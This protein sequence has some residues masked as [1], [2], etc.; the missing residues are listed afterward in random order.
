V[1]VDDVLHRLGEAVGGGPGR[2]LPGQRDGRREHLGLERLG[3]PDRLG[4][5]GAVGR[6]ASSLE[7]QVDVPPQA[8]LEHG[9]L[10]R[11]Q[12]PRAQVCGADGR[13]L[14]LQELPPHVE[15]RDRHRQREPE[16]QCHQGER[17]RDERG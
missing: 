13:R 6:A 11:R 5:P 10:G 8:V 2:G 1:D 14:G 16:Q 7:T 15:A 9:A 17:P 12:Q 3:G 4:R